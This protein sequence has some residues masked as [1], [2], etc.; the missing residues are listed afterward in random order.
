MITDGEWYWATSGIS[1]NATGFTDWHWHE[2]NGLASENCMEFYASPDGHWNDQ[3]CTFKLP[4]VCQ[5]PVDRP[6]VIG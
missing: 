1:F 3:L 4:F 2:P 6:V 5:R